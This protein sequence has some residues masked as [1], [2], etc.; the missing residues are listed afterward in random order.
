MALGAAYWGAFGEGIVGE[1]WAVIGCVKIWVSTLPGYFYGQTCDVYVWEGGVSGPPGAVLDLV[2]GV[3]L[4]NV[5]N[6]P[7]VGEND[8]QV[9]YPLFQEECT[10][11]YW[12]NWPGMHCA[13]YVGADLD[14]FGGGHP[15]TYI[16]PGIGYPTGWND[17]S[18]IWGPMQSLGLGAVY[19]WNSPA[20]ARS[21]GSIKA[22]FR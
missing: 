4:G 2:A 1:P 22:L 19:A 13:Y 17:P 16:A 6:W 8:V 21:W 14:G 10:V 18:I 20:E 3:V 5:P 12:G 15:W 11:G 7:T 9:H